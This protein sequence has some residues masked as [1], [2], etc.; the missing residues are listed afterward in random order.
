[1]HIRHDTKTSRYRVHLPEW[2]W[3]EEPVFP[4]IWYL[5]YR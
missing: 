5:H 2:R 1:M 3:G 4:L